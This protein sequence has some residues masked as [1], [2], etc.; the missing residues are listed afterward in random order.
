[1]ASHFEQTTR[2]SE[3]NATT[4]EG[5]RVVFKTMN[6]REN[7]QKEF[8][9]GDITNGYHKCMPSATPV[10]SKKQKA[11]VKKADIDTEPHEMVIASR[12]PVDVFNIWVDRDALSDDDV[13]RLIEL[14][15]IAQ[16]MNP[17]DEIE[18]QTSII[19]DDVPETIETSECLEQAPDD[20]SFDELTQPKLLY[21]PPP[22][23]ECIYND[24][25]LSE[26]NHSVF[27]LSA[28]SEDLFDE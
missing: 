6:N 12:K 7:I 1:M 18:P 24:P 28:D 14:D 22:T 13:D 11:M 3:N 19:E 27:D 2:F 15:I 26:L 4:F 25:E 23:S 9:L 21:L 16:N 8:A 20:N 17:Y 10:F 5:K